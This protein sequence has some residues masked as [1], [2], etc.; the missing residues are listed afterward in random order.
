MSE[1][2]HL[3]ASDYRSMFRLIG[4]CRD[5][6]ADPHAW[7]L[8]LLTQLCARL[9]ARVGAGGEATGMAR[10][11]FIPLSTVDMGWENDAQR[12][13]MFEWMEFQSQQNSPA[14]LLPF[15]G[16]IARSLVVGRDDVFTDDQWY[17][18]V[19]FCDYVRRSELDHILLSLQRIAL[20]PDHF[21]GLMIMRSLGERRFAGRDKLFLATLHGELAPMVGRQLAAAH[22]P[23]AMQLSPRLRQVLEGLL[24]GNAE[25][26]IAQRLNLKTQ[27]VNQYVKAIYR[28][29]RVNSRAQLMARWIRFD[30]GRPVN[31]HGSTRFE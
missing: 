14:A 7:R 6:G 24:E 23:S 5:L 13:A 31:S 19:Q 16:P 28:H 27:T 4:E 20:G 21:C 15:P 10:Q 9:G 29:F 8:H 3:R 18:S 30:R 25:K 22:E 26:Q 1:T 11:Q 12:Q 2:A 17:N